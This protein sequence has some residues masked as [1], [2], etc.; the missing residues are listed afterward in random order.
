MIHANL[1]DRAVRERAHLLEW[2]HE[3]RSA[4][5]DRHSRGAGAARRLVRGLLTGGSADFE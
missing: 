4:S 3:A 1:A 5:A 2:A